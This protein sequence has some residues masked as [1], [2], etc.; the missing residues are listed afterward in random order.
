[1]NADGWHPGK[2]TVEGRSQWMFRVGASQIGMHERL[3]RR[4]R[5]EGSASA[6]VP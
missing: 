2:V 4:A 5:E 1:M 3:D 6:R